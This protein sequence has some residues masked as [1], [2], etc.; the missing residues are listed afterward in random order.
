MTELSFLRTDALSPDLSQH[1]RRGIFVT[2]TDTEVGKTF[3][4]AALTR[5]LQAHY[6]KPVQT[7]PV[8]D[9]DQ[10]TVQR[11][12]GLPDSH[13]SA[14]HSIFP[15]PLSPHE[16]AKRVGKTL[17]FASV[18]FP[19]VEGDPFWLVEGA[20]GALVPLDDTH[21]MT[22]LMKVLGLPVVIVSRS[23][24]GTIN[25][26]LLTLEA[27]RSRAIEVA[28]VIMNGPENPANRE[29]IEN[30]GKVEV[31]AELPRLD[32]VTSKTMESLMPHLDHAADILVKRSRGNE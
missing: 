31:L 17:D 30:Y 27:L 23:G 9:H 22:D 20:G 26:T 24:L 21:L 16:A 5:K 3:V 13:F 28:G 7:G 14:C 1:L 15:D 6:W 8:E 12:S 2:G 11:L 18:D 32:T 4:S 29:A 10:P 19:A 25:H